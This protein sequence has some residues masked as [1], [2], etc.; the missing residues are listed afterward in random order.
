MKCKLFTLRLDSKTIEGQQEEFNKFLET[1]KVEK[2]ATQFVP[3]NPDFW[4]VLVF[5]SE[6][7]V[8]AQQI[9]EALSPEQKAYLAALRIW[10]KDRAND[11]NIPE[12]MI[13]HNATL[14]EIVKLMPT[15]I[16]E[17]TSIKGLGNSKIARYGDDIVAICAALK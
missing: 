4:S 10:R 17:L 8:S 2:T 6:Q 7:P 16:L 15:T 9:E 11:A 13:C 5:Y 1:V 14:V 3:G 12:F